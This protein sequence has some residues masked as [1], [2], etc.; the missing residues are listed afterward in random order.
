MKFVKMFYEFAAQA[1]NF[2]FVTL[3]RIEYC[4]TP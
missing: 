3:V 2:V 4:A 1:I